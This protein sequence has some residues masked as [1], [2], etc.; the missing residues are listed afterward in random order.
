MDIWSAIHPPSTFSAPVKSSRPTSPCVTHTRTQTHTYAQRH[1]VRGGWHR[2]KSG[3][4]ATNF[5]PWDFVKL[6]DF[7]H[8]CTDANS[9]QVV[10]TLPA[11][12]ESGSELHTCRLESHFWVSFVSS[13]GTKQ[14]FSPVSL[15]LRCFFWNCF[16]GSTQLFTTSL[17]TLHRDTCTRSDWKHVL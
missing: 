16:L 15:K 12:F 5:S 13:R 1:L 4:L 6:A 3:A 7:T 14:H 10:I 8:R 2:C 9:A 17:F 11:C